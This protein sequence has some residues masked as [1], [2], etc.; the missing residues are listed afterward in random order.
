MWGACGSGPWGR[1]SI[2]VTDRLRPVD[3]TVDNPKVDSGV[4]V[5]A[6]ELDLEGHEMRLDIIVLKADEKSMKIEDTNG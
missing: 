1:Q 4:N 6:E 5:V 2:L 3:K